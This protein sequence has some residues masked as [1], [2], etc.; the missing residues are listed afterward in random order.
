MSTV[1]GTD[2]NYLYYNDDAGGI[3]KTLVG[4][5]TARVSHV[6]T[7]AE[8]NAL[9]AHIPV[10]WRTPFADPNYTISWSIEDTISAVDSDYVPG[11]MHQVTPAGFLAVILIGI[12]TT[13]P[14]G[15]L[16]NIHAIGIHD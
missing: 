2:G 8:I 7:Q 12:A 13:P 1:I 4:I 14:A 16:L 6:V 9:E 11:D 5:R 10:L 3:Q 15:A